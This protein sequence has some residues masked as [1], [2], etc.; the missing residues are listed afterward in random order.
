MPKYIIGPIHS[1]VGIQRD[2]TPYFSQHYTSGQWC[3]FYDHQAR[4]MGGFRLIDPASAIIIRSMYSVPDP[5]LPYQGDYFYL[6]RYNGVNGITS[7]Y[8]GV[9]VSGEIPRPISDETYFDPTNQD[10]LWDFEQ[11]TNVDSAGVV[12]PYIVAQ[13][14]PNATNISNPT[15]GSVFYGGIVGAGPLTPVKDVTQ[16]NPSITPNGRYITASGGVVF[17]SPV[18][19]AYGDNGIIQWSAPGVIDSWPYN[20]YLVIANSKIIKGAQS[21]GGT[22]FWTLDTLSLAN[23]TLTPSTDPL[24]PTGQYG[25]TSQVIEPQITVMS[26][27]SIT[28]FN[29]VFYWVGTDYFYSYSGVVTKVSNTMNTDWFFNNINLAQRAK[30]W[31]IVIGHYS[32]IWWFY[33]R[34][35][36]G[37]PPEEY[38]NY[39]EC[40]AAIIY[41]VEH[42]VWYD[43]AINRSAGLPVSIFPYPMMASSVIGRDGLNYPLFMHEIGQDEVDTT[44]DPVTNYAILSNFQTHLIDL[45]TSDAS[46]TTLIRNRRLA[47]DFAQVGGMQVQI[48][49]QDYPAE[50]PTIDG[51]YTFYPAPQTMSDP[52]VTPYLDFATQGGIVSF[53]FESNTVGGFYQGG[54]TLFFYNIGDT[55]K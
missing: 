36:P 42:N 17:V 47:P 12:T 37:T 33:P 35:P 23:A 25:F 32:E 2:S 10:N 52:P 21:R 13:V 31:S 41:N 22:L 49:Y 6:G 45:W 20:N 46:N 29:Q 44:T 5:S 34:I 30:V 54:K 3:R 27:A 11:F 1:K 8:N 50:T 16:T 51:P 39:T 24:Y 14:A 15:A 53:A 26:P 43:T 4:K 38:D 19:V 40:N 18:L 48:N 7:D 55:L 9:T 28:S